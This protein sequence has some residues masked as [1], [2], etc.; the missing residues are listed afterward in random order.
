[1]S[2]LT[3]GLAVGFVTHG[4]KKMV[5]TRMWPASV[6][7]LSAISQAPPKSWQSVQSG[8]TDKHLEFS[9]KERL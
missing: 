1:M 9:S 4:R 7:G 8:A 5:V 6:N 2:V 3:K